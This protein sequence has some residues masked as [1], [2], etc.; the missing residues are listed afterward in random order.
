[1]DELWQL[2]Q[3]LNLWDMVFVLVI[4]VS[5]L[6]GLWR[7][8]LFEVASLASVI[9]AFFGAQWAAHIVQQMLPATGVLAHPQMSWLL[10]FL[11][12]FLGISVTGTLLSNLV[13]KWLRK[14]GLGGLDRLLGMFFGVARALVLL[15]VV[16]VVVVATPLRDSA[17]WQQSVSAPLLQISLQTL[18]PLLPPTLIAGLQADAVP[19]IWRQRGADVISALPQLAASHAEAA[20]VIKRQ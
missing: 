13:R 7:G 20:A 19:D 10:A 14:A 2:A 6:M 18:T 12:V 8:L 15:W 1:M 3:Q 16:T 4:A 5:A 17:S 11:L 9:V